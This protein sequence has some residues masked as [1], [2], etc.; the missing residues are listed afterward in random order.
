MVDERLDGDGFSRYDLHLGLIPG[1]YA[2]GL[3]AQAMFPVSLTLTLVLASVVAA[4]G[5]FDA[6]VVHPPA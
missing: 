5:L 2:V 1:A 6:L 4:T 3:A